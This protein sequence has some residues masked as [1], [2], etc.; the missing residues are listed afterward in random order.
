MR[1]SRRVTCAPMFDTCLQPFLEY[2]FV[3]WVYF[4]PGPVS[5]GFRHESG[6]DHRDHDHRAAQHPVL[7][8]FFRLAER[9][10]LYRSAFAWLQICL[11]GILL[12]GSPLITVAQQASE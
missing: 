3:C 4:P 6:Q 11:L 12:L 10:M 1:F 8:S 5:R 7:R 2:G 9:L